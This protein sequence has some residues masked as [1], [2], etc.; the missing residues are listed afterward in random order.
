MGY[1]GLYRRRRYQFTAE[2]QIAELQLELARLRTEAT[3]ATVHPVD[4]PPPGLPPFNYIAPFSGIDADVAGSPLV[5]FGCL[6]LGTD[7][8]GPMFGG[9]APSDHT[10]VGSY[11]VGGFASAPPLPSLLSAATPLQ[12]WAMFVFNLREGSYSP[13]NPHWLHPL[14]P[15]VIS[16]LMFHG[17]AVN[18][19][20]LPPRMPVLK[21]S[22]RHFCN[23]GSSLSAFVGGN[24]TGM[25]FE[26][27]VFFRWDSGL[28]PDYKRAATRTYW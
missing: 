21:D 16:L 24:A 10:A 25:N 2:A 7:P 4:Q 22:L 27:S 19:T 11:P 17:Y 18:I 3:S 20:P 26:E 9:G 12:L 13:G 15:E 6:G 8:A 1:F 23:D 5:A 14:T 28:A